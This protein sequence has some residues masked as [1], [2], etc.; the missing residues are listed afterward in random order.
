MVLTATAQNRAARS[1]AKKLGLKTYPS[2]RPCIH[3][4]TGERYVRNS[5]CLACETARALIGDVDAKRAYKAQWYQRNHERLKPIQAAKYAASKEIISAK[6]KARRLANPEA[7]AKR[8]AVYRQRKLAENPDFEKKR[9][10]QRR[11]HRED[12]KELYRARHA[13]YRAEHPEVTRTH[14]ANR[15]ARKRGAEGRH[16]KEEIAELLI[17]QRRRCGYCRSSLKDGFHVDHI[18]SI[19]RGGSNWIRNIQLLCQPCN[20]RKHAKHP[21]DFAREIGLLI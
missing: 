17:A 6:N 9:Y 15:M 8:C 11:E 1:E 2:L 14:N 18:I 5:E 13:Q 21:I 19:S 10:P 12:N 20:Q 4:H 3:G 7:N 16:T